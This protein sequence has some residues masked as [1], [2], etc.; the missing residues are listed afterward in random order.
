MPAARDTAKVDTSIITERYVKQQLLGKTREAPG[1]SPNA[2]ASY[3]RNFASL[4]RRDYYILVVYQSLRHFYSFQL[5]VFN[6]S[7]LS[8]F[9]FIFGRHT[10]GLILRIHFLHWKQRSSTI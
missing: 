8:L 1:K 10:L 5:P 6:L 4:V 9:N 7:V 2:V 3:L